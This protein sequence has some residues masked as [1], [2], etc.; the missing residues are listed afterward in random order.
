MIRQKK[1]QKNGTEVQKMANEN[2]VTISADEYFNLRQKAELNG[3]LM[4][5]LGEMR[6]KLVDFD[7]RLYHAENEIR[8]TQ[9]GK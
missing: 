8:R 1:Q 7:N 9:D 3:F 5:E 2:T 6:Q 4:V